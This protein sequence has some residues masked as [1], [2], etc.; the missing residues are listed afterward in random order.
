MRDIRYWHPFEGCGVSDRN[1]NPENTVRNGEKSYNCQHD[2]LSNETARTRLSV[3]S[4]NLSNNYGVVEKDS[5]IS[6]TNLYIWSI[7]IPKGMEYLTSKNLLHGDL[8]LRNVLLTGNK[9]A[10]ICDFGL[11]RSLYTKSEYDKKS[12]SPLPLKWMAIDIFHTSQ[13]FGLLV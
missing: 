1:S 2:L 8:A 11:S 7:H 12:Y 4:D 9:I 6:T 13:M 10:K 3:E 5:E